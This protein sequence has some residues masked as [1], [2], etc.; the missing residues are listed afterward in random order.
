MEDQ[1]TNEES[2]DASGPRRSLREDGPADAHQEKES[3][4]GADI[5]RCTSQ[6]PMPLSQDEVINGSD[7]ESEDS[8]EEE[9][10]S[11]SRRC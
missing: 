2:A 1:G 9:I 10:A 6:S 7:E 4:A 8:G 5:N 3:K 11:Q